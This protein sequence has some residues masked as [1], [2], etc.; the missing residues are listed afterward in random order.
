MLGK[1]EHT[2][3]PCTKIN[4][5]CL[6]DFNIRHDTIKLLEENIDKTHSDISHSN[7]FLGQ[8]LKAIEIKIK[9]KKW[10]PNQTYKFLHS[11]GNH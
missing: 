1:L 8:F 9:I 11:K 3:T 4:S 2:L 10:D 7:T 5:K 6:K